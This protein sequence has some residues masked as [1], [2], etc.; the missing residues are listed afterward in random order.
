M[1]N[2]PRNC[3]R[4]LTQLSQ[5]RPDRPRQAPSPPRAVRVPGPQVRVA[6]VAVMHVLDKLEPTARHPRRLACLGEP[7]DRRMARPQLRRQLLHPPAG[8]AVLPEIG[9]ALQHALLG[10]LARHRRPVL[11]RVRVDI[12]CRLMLDTGTY[13][14]TRSSA[15]RG[16]M[17]LSGS[18]SQAI[19]TYSCIVTL[20]TK[21][22]ASCMGSAQHICRDPTS[23]LVM[24]REPA[25][26]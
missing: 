6:L 1:I 13:A 8:S 24:Q 22:S 18:R 16:Y 12:S 19:E 4:S 2:N 26:R 7:T 5:A 9:L 21:L 14:G 17:Q 3:P 15:D 11:R 25:Q 20:R 23:G 10:A